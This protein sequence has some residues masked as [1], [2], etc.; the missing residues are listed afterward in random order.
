[1]SGPH[2][3]FGPDHV[4][5]K[6]L[7]RVEIAKV[8]RSLQD[9][10]AF[11]NF[12][13]QNGWENRTLR[14]IEPEVTEQLK[15]KRPHSGDDIMSDSSSS[16][17][18][19]Q[20]HNNPFPSGSSFGRPQSHA[21]QATFKASQHPNK[22]VRS[23]STAGDGLA[24]NGI[25]WKQNHNLPQSSPAF[26]R[27]H[28]SLGSSHVSFMSEATAIPDSQPDTSPMFD[29]SHTTQG[30]DEDLPMHSFHHPSS[31]S[32]IS[33]SP[34]RTPPTRHARNTNT[35]QDGADLLLYLANSPS[36][37]PG[38]R[39]LHASQ[40]EQPSTP[41]SQHSHL[42][43]SVMN[44]PGVGL[45]LQTPG[46]NFNFA[47]FVNVTPSPAQ[48]TWGA[49]TPGMPKTPGAT[50]LARRSLNFDTLAPPTGSLKT[51]QKIPTSKGLALELGGE[52]LPRS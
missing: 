13:A 7:R 11:A 23:M 15:R 1:M 21:E 43:S 35:K 18:D 41:P 22:R 3:P 10:L 17:D 8:A 52:L 5:E 47:D 16:E 30:E 28:T 6:V 45:F 20:H 27:P 32:I 12:K 37:S 42:P 9:C 51:E 40:Q 24:S 2:Y 48:L 34:P 38:P 25:S 29:I 31:S 33:S 4:A 39:N 46:Q 14:T 50:R 26:Q 19:L 36:R 49:R 44:T